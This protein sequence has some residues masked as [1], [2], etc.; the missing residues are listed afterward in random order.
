MTT[1]TTAS[2]AGVRVAALAEIPPGEGR[3]YAVPTSDGTGMQ[4]VA[5]F[6]HR[7][8][9]VSAVDAVCPHS[10]GPLADGQIDSCVVICPLHLNTWDLRTGESTSGQDPV[11]VHG[12]EVAPDGSVVVTPA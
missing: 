11:R 9:H 1:T 3:A 10:G 2:A 12:V 6:H 4:Q 7:D 8:G 5:V